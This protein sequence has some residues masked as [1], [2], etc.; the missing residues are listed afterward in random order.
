TSIAVTGDFAQTNNCSSTLAPGA[1]CTVSVTFTPRMTGT[2]SGTLTV[3]D[4]ASNGSPQSTSL[5]GTGVDFAISASP[6]SASI[7]AGNTAS[8]TVTVSALGG[9]FNWAVSLA[10]SGLP[11]SAKCSFSSSS[12]TPGTGSVS[13][14]LSIS[15]TS[16]SRVTPKGT[17]TI[18]IA[19]TSGSLK[20]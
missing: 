16:G 17:Y 1:S 15:T 20:E 11:K 9:N 18:T 3:S 2:R 5:S 8:S 4:D 14:G 10:C 6:S 19:G 13:S 7:T 12:L